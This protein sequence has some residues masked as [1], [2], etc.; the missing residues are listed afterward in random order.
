MSVNIKEEIENINEQLKNNL[1][2]ENNI[3]ITQS[4][5]QTKDWRKSQEWYKNGKSNECELYQIKFPY[6]HD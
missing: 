3:I 6:I 4:I 2:L 5:S 1:N